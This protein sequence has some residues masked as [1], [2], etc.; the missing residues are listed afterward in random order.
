MR[1]TIKK[2]RL[3]KECLLAH[4]VIGFVSSPC[5]LAQVTPTV[6]ELLVT[7]QM[8]EESIQD[9]PL[10]VGIYDKAFIEQIGAGS[11]VDMEAAVPSVNFGGGYRNTRGEIV[12][13]GIGDYARNIGTN[14]R[15]AVY[16]DGVLTGRSSSFD[17]S[18]LD[19]VRIEVLR[20]PQGTLAGTNALAGAINIITQK[21]TDTLG[22][23]LI[24]SAGN[25][26]LGSI[27][28][29][30][31]IPLTQDLFASL[32]L[33]ASEQ[34]GYIENIT[35]NRDLQGVNR[36]N[37][38]LKLHYRGIDSLTLDFGIDYLQ[39]DELSTNAEALAN[40]PF[41]GF[42][43][44]PGAYVVAHSA[45]EFQQRELKGVSIEAVYET[46]ENYCWTSISGVRR[47]AFRE[48]ND[49][50]FSPL[51]AAISIFD[52]QSDQWSQEIRLA[53]PKSEVLD[54]VVGVYFLDQDIST[55]RQAIT[56][57]VFRLAPNSS[58]QTPARAGV[59]SAS[60]SCMATIISIRAG[61]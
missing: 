54:Y 58:I 36:D 59:E 41:N 19:V 16:I 27:I 34:D 30:I 14:A 42:T 22:A 47:N 15:V 38:K 51:D 56:G 40:G 45:D 49:E 26:D 60:L 31:N 5:V 44:A 6:E 39:D 32:L 28:G 61:V 20:G 4:L 33:A 2:Q 25:Y 29:K 55:G 21:P 18:L 11:L 12:I 57:P 1:I 17:Q 35:L 8:R 53:S 37:A 3:V 7:A 23:E 9:I 43:R 24:A 13:R 46:P 10:S 48:L 50:D 52:E